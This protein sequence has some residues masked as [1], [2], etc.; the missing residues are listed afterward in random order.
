LDFQ[1]SFRQY[2]IILNQHNVKMKFIGCRCEDVFLTVLL[3]PFLWQEN[4]NRISLSAIT[5]KNK[6]KIKQAYY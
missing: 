3:F 2:Y 5:K 6:Q 1:I 4:Q